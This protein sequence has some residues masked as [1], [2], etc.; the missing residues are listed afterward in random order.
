[1]DAISGMR[2]TFAEPAN[3]NPVQKTPAGEGGG[4]TETLA[5]AMDHVESLR[6]DAQ[7]QVASLL[8]G[9]GGELHSTMIAVEKADV[10]F[11]LMMQMRNKIVS[12]YEEVARMQF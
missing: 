4:F 11:Q 2:I 3:P 9:N 12:A 6:T 5:N 10:A 8:S 7:Q 1:M